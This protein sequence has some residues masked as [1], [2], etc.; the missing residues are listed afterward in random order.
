MMWNWLRFLK[1]STIAVLKSNKSHLVKI[2]WMRKQITAATNVDIPAAGG[3]RRR[4]K[5]VFYIA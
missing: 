2:S 5:F 4:G 3:T 1:N